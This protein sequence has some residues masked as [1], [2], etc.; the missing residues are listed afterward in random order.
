MYTEFVLIIT[1]LDD[2]TD[3]ITPE[4]SHVIKRSAKLISVTCM[5]IDCIQ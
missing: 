3:D 2:V 5:V 4:H 1:I